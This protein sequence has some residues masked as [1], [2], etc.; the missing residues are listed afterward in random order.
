MEKYNVS[1]WS[2]VLTVGY[3][4]K[5]SCQLVPVHTHF[6]SRADHC[7]TVLHCVSAA[8]VQ[9]LQNV[10]NA[11]VC[12]RKFDHITTD[13]R[14]QLHWLPVQQR[15]EYK[16]CVL[17]Y[18]CLHQAAPTYLAELCSPVSELANRGHLRSATRGDLAVPRSR[19]RRYGQRCF[20][21]SG[22][23]L[24]NSLPLSAH[25]PS[26]TLTQFCV[27]LKTVLFCRAYSR[28]A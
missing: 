4:S 5:D 10:L 21:V 28:L 14:D 8:S 9:P 23:T 18:E 15:I 2:S 11:A 6:T 27:R 1:L 25:D 20:A 26:L 13:V 17:V 22:P 7:N 19:T 3:V 24:W 12:K 16:V